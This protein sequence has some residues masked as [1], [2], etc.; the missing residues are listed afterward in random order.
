MR[1]WRT[2]RADPEAR[3]IADRHYNR[4]KVGSPQFVPPGRCVVLSTRDGAVWVT[5]WPFGEYVKHRW[6]GLW[7]NSLFRNET[8][9]LSSELILEAVAATRSIWDPPEGG[10]VS[11]VDPGKTRP[12]R[13]PGFCY[14]KAGFEYDGK[15]QGGLVA[16][17][18]RPDRMPPAEAP[19]LTQPR[20]I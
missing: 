11:F 14:L 3:R 17:V 5:S 8:T 16:L 10:L 19:L 6:P 9:H 4:R 15:T 7:V 12:K 20:L 18:L 13:H 1:W 2:H